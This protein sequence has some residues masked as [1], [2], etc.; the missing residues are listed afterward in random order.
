M[1]KSIISALKVGYQG[2]HGLHLQ[3]AHLINNILPG[4]GAIQPR[5]RY[6]FGTFLPGTVFSGSDDRSE[7]NLFGEHRESA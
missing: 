3:R 6:P 7:F 4:A 5:R 1:Q 2:E